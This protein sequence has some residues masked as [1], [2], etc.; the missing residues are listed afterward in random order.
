MSDTFKKHWQYEIEKN[1]ALERKLE[2]ARGRI[3]DY[4]YDLETLVSVVID[5][6]NKMSS[7]ECYDTLQQVADHYKKLKEQ[8][9]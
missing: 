6:L 7:G 3:D 9:E 8:G 5:C 4:K 1:Q 2:E